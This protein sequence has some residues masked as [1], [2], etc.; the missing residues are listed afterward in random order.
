MSVETLAAL[1]TALAALVPGIT[2]LVLA[3]RGHTVINK[4]IKPQITEL[5][6]GNGVHD[7]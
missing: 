5:K 3:I 2:A 1:V 4:E 7:G 6:N